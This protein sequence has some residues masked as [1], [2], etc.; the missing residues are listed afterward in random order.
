MVNSDALPDDIKAVAEKIVILVYTSPE[1]TP[2]EIGFA[3]YGQ[4]VEKQTGVRRST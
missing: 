2:D 3:I 1:L 4:C